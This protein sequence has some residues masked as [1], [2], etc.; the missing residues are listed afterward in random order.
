MPITPSLPPITVTLLTTWQ[1]KLSGGTDEIMIVVSF[2]Q[3]FWSVTLT[4]YKP[5]SRQAFVPDA[6]AADQLIALL[7]LVMSDTQL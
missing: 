5:A 2:S 7:L 6:P 4:E 3:P 1:L